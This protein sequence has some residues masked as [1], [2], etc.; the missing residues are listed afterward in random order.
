M[1]RT[2]HLG[3]PSGPARVHDELVRLVRL[4]LIG[5]FAGACLSHPEPEDHPEFFL[6][7]WLCA[8]GT[9]EIDCGEGVRTANLSLGPP[10]AIR[11]VEGTSSELL[12]LLPSESLVPGSPDG[13]SCSLRFDV[14]GDLTVL[15]APTSC[16]G[17]GQ[18]ISVGGARAER[19]LARIYLVTNASTDEG[20]NVMTF[21]RC[22]AIEE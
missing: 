4:V 9:R 12:L 1:S 10:T 5:T 3:I 7:D 17:Q 14:N 8:S 6:G 19:I 16:L 15:E 2:R 13:S 22:E 11:F 21:N 20:C 18:A